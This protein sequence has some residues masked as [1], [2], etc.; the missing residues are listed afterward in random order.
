MLQCTNRATDLQHFKCSPLYLILY[1]DL[2]FFLSFAFLHVTTVQ[3]ITSITDTY[4][5]KT[6]YLKN[7]C[8]IRLDMLN[9]PGNNNN[10]TILLLCCLHLQSGPITV[11]QECFIIFYFVRK[12]VLCMHNITIHLYQSYV[13]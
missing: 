7:L 5:C 2:S 9:C 6:F 10:I 8:L 13:S 4:T 3:A 1:C 11:L 12:S